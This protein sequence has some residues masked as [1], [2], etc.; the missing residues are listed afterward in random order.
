MKTNFLR[1]K[2]P[3]WLSI[4]GAILLIGLIM[5]LV[6]GF[7]LSV[8]ERD[9]K[10]VSV[11]YDAYLTLD[12]SLLETAEDTCL[13]VIDEY[14]VSLKQVKRASYTS[15]GCFEFVFEDSVDTAT[16]ESVK[17]A[18]LSALSSKEGVSQAY[19]TASV[20]AN[21]MAVNA[22]YIG[23][24]AIALGCAIVIA[25]AYVAIRFR[26]G[27]GVTVAALAVHD[28]LMVLAFTAITRI[29][30]TIAFV[31]AVAFAL[32]ISLLLSVLS[33]VYV[34][35]LKEDENLKAMPQEE[36]FELV[37]KRA[38][39]T[40]CVFSALALVAIVGVA[41]L[42]LIS[43]VS[44]LTFAVPAAFAVL[45]SAYSS[46][47]LLPVIYMPMKAIADKR[48][49][50]KAIKYVAAQKKTVEESSNSEEENID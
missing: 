29:P 24:F 2:W 32:A 17:D 35:S 4:S 9:T 12:E 23:R 22:A 14:S 7:H 25:F 30:V 48:A 11:N 15:G 38:R 33:F 36:A 47:C 28:V 5:F 6:F 49:A 26:L 44:L 43:S 21:V 39:K 37:M 16:L 13:T 31:G 27:A 40:V 20:N 50:E 46:I 10:S 1:K 45:V 42:S 19:Y 3:V 8:T 18:M 34:R 41:L